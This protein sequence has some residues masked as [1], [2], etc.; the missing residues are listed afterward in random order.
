GPISLV[1]IFLRI[2]NAGLRKIEVVDLGVLRVDV[3]DCVTQDSNGFDRVDA[4][5]EHV[6][7]I[8]IATDAVAGNGAEL[9]HRLRTVNN[10]AGVHLNCD[11]YSMIFGELAVLDPIWSD[12]LLP[13]PVE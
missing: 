4:L 11:L 7:W 2:E 13:L 5:P 10:K 3:E 12:F 6:A 8:L 1:C 9:Q